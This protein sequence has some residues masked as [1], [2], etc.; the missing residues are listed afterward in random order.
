MKNIAK[1]FIF[2]TV[3]VS[4]F[5][6]C[7]TPT[8]DNNKTTEKGTLFVYADTASSLEIANDSRGYT[9]PDTFLNESNEV[10]ITIKNTGDG[11]IKLTGKPYIHLDG[12]TTVFSVSV[13]PEAST[14]NPG[15]FVSFKIKFT[16]LNAVE[17]YVYVSIPNDSKN[18]PDISFTVYGK[19]IRSKPVA[20]ILY[21]N[22][23]ILQ[24]GPIN[25][26]EVILTQPKCITVII[27]NTGKEVLTVETDYISISG[28]EKEAFIIKD[29]PAQNISPGNQ[30]QLIIEC[31]P[32]K[33]GGN[34]ATLKIPTNDSSR[35]QVEVY[36]QAQAIKGSAVLYLTQ[37]SEVIANNSLTPVDFGRIEKGTDKILNFT[38]KNTGNI[39]LDLIGTPVVSSSNSVFTVS[40]QPANTALTPTATTAFSIQYTP[41]VGGTVTGTITIANN[42]DE[43]SFSFTVKGNSIPATPTG[44]SIVYQSPN[45]MLL[46]WNP[47]QGATSYRVYYGTNSSAI[48]F[49]ADSAV[50]GTS[51]THTGL[52]AGTT[53][54]Y[55]ITAQDDMSESNR[56]QAVSK[57]TLP[58][59]PSNLR[60]TAS[61]Y[62]STTIAWNTVTGAT[63]YNV[64]YAASIEGSKTFAGTVSSTSYNHTNLSANTT[65]YYFVTAVNSTGEGAYTEA[66][67]ARTLLAPLSA[68]NNV[69]ATALSTTSI[70]ITWESVAGAGSY[71]VY[72]ATSATGTRTLLDT[73]STT[74]F[75]SGGLTER[76]YWYFVTAL[77]TDNVE[78]A[79]SASASMVPKP[80]APVI[81]V[82]DYGSTSITLDWNNKDGYSYKIYFGANLTGTK[83]LAGISTTNGRYT[84]EGLQSNRTYYYWV[85]A[86]NTGG[87]SEYSLPVS[88]VT[89]PAAPANFRQ[90][91]NTTTTVTLAW[92]AVSG[93]TRYEIYVA[94]SG[95]Y[96]TSLGSTTDT[97]VIITDLSSKT[98]YTFYVAAYN[99]NTGLE[100]PKAVV[101]ASTK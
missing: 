77:N 79:L 60:S 43:T 52:L 95:Y 37:G 75:T 33:Q 11:I 93:A 7:D 71:K 28:T 12:A 88:A 67:S 45:S 27:K 85:I 91:A 98:T 62:N 61:T 32:N 81:K 6:T 36:L 3:L 72:R 54:F 59:I 23:E 69:T 44:V 70:Q 4:C 64:Y 80:S 1:T 84:H 13:L 35:L 94:W 21:N 8:N 25:V 78:G 14:I 40:S 74:S 55:C 50:T 46:S 34:N 22:T 19:G 15:E 48:T 73:V 20:T 38:I 26:G 101:T 53:Y 100:G 30:S 41:T 17:S 63:S 82:Y 97:A 31:N 16:P 47:V 18:E 39:R 9:F 66:F 89:E 49:L 29:P 87:E 83:T 99:G 92:N 56:S 68:P 2:L 5:T 24:N 51:Y 57:I 58:G 65:R 90:T 86:V 76:T 96:L 42:S 10:S